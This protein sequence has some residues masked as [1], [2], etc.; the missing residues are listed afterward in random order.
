MRVLSPITPTVLAYAGTTI[1]I[2]VLADL[3]HRTGF[4]KTIPATIFGGLL[5]GVVSALVSVPVTTF[6]YGGVSLAGADAVTTLFKASGLPVWQSVLFGG[7]ITDPA[8]KLATAIIC[9]FMVRSLPPSLL[10]RF[11]GARVVTGENG[12]LPRM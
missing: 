2:A 3:F 7:L 5:I 1:A 11:G 10:R 4:L 6:L 12:G 9:L 8:D